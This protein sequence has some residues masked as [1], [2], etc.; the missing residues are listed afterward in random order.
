MINPLEFISPLS[1]PDTSVRPAAQ[2]A[3]TE[4]PGRHNDD[5]LTLS[6]KGRQAVEA[7]RRALEDRRQPDWMRDF[8]PEPLMLDLPGAIAETRELFA[9]LEEERA[10]GGGLS[11]AG[12]RLY[13]D[14][15]ADTSTAS[16]EV[17]SR[18]SFMHEHERE[19]SEYMDLLRQAFHEARQE[20][21]IVTQDDYVAQ[22]LNV[23]GDNP[24]LRDQVK[25]KLLDNPRA[26]TLMRELGVDPLK[27]SQS[28]PSA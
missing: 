19:I 15:L 18:L 26:V 14:H 13:S 24:E 21:G 8:I 28:S 23:P 20:Q 22:V 17:R 1:R 11:E 16:Y 2:T 10:A 9:R 12:R 25:G 4:H 3:T 27:A 5:T 7:E 6:T